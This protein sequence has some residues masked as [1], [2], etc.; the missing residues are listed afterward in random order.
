MIIAP[1]FFL[2]PPK[3]PA[4][5]VVATM[6]NPTRS[7]FA[8]IRKSCRA[9]AAAVFAACVRLCKCACG[10]HLVERQVAYIFVLVYSKL[11]RCTSLRMCNSARVRNLASACSFFLQL[12]FESP[13]T[14]TSLCFVCC[15]FLYGANGVC[16]GFCNNW[17]DVGGCHGKGPLHA[18]KSEC[19][20]TPPPLPL[21]FLGHLR[22]E[23]PLGKAE[24]GNHHFGHVPLGGVREL[25]RQCV[26]GR[27]VMRV[28][29]GVGHSI[30]PSGIW[31]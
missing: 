17:K 31:P 19:K 1:V 28:A 29:V 8:V 7:D 18:K 3:H 21:Q 27:A 10:I 30:A 23:H 5:F 4:K 14:G 20:N 15:A 26:R 11:R 13:K 24:Q 25:M 6:E 16:C 22:L 9:R 12:F 2:P